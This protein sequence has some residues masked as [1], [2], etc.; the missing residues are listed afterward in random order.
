MSKEYT[1]ALTIFGNIPTGGQIIF[2]DNFEDLLKWTKSGTGADYVVELDPSVAF[3]GKQSL[4]LSTRLTDPAENDEVSAL[5][6]SHMLPSQTLTMTVI[7]RIPDPENH[8]YVTFV[9]Y[10]HNGI[11]LYHAN[12]RYSVM[13]PI[14]SYKNSEGSFTPLDPMPL[15]IYTNSWHRITLRININTLL[16]TD[17]SLDHQH[18]DLSSALLR[19][20]DN[21]L[22]RMGGSIILNT[23]HNHPFYANIDEVI[24]H[25]I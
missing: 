25:E 8:K 13:D 2:Y 11:R 15:G 6:L 4:F 1:R 17:F 18:F 24:I 23:I 19:P 16:Y 10:A 7:F 12:I 21:G 3:H 22:S 9:L 5:F 20:I 14:W